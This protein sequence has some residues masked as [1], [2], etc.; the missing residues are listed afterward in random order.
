VY[1]IDKNIGVRIYVAKTLDVCFRSAY[2]C[3]IDAPTDTKVQGKP[4]D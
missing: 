4:T 3:K 2:N 1:A